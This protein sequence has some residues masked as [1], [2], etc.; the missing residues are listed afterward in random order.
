MKRRLVSLSSFSL[1]AVA[2]LMTACGGG[3]DSP[4]AAPAAPATVAV[5]AL[6]PTPS[7]GN[8]STG[9]TQAGSLQYMVFD[10]N[11]ATTGVGTVATAAITTAGN[12]TITFPAAAPFSSGLVISDS[13]ANQG[14]VFPSNTAGGVSDA[15]NV[16]FYCS[17]GQSTQASGEP[18]AQ[19]GEY[20]AFSG[21][22]TADTDVA[23]LYGKTFSEKNCTNAPNTFTFGD[24]K[25]N[26][27]L[28]IK[29]FDNTAGPS[30][31]AAQLLNAFTAGGVTL[32]VGTG[33]TATVRAR[34]Y[35]SVVAGVTHHF[36]ALI[37]DE[38]Q[39]GGVKHTSVL[40]TP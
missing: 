10:A 4:P 23:Y 35:S 22:T 5:T 17:A 2:V 14:G 29:Q 9:T 21:N 39:A 16:F 8:S 36:V 34:S 11:S 26:L 12:G 25:G 32:T 18:V 13:N 3:S 1:V 31:T 37:L 7:T 30:L 24:G 15:G 40:Y 20:V 27:T 38:S 33:A 19:G 28:S 6:T